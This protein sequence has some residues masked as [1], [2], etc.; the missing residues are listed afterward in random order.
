M[1]CYDVEGIYNQQRGVRDMKHLI[2]A[3]CALHG[4]IYREESANMW[5]LESN[6]DVLSMDR[7]REE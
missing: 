6:A 3:R 1:L 2:G 4:C 7:R 5:W